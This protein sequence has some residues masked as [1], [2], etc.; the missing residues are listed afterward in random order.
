M[1]HLRLRFRRRHIYLDGQNG[2]VTHSVHQT[3]RH[4]WH[5]DEILK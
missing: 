5:I 1:Q 3:L 2:F 4:H